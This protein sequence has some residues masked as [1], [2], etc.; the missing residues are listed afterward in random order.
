MNGLDGLR[1]SPGFH[2]ASPSTINGWGYL[3]YREYTRS[4]TLWLPVP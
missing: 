3:H 2:C 4:I 1:G